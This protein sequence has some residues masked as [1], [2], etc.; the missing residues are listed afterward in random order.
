MMRGDGNPDL[1][2]NQEPSELYVI[3]YQVN[4][5]TYLLAYLVI[6]LFVYLKTHIGIKKILLIKM[7]TI[8]L[9]HLDI[10]EKI[11]YFIFFVI[12]YKCAFLK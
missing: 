5:I 9:I 2:N 8:I 4:S 3:F 11:S 12:I 6:N 10:K 7:M 1:L